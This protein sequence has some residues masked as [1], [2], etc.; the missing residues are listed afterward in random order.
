MVADEIFTNY[1]I[2]SQS[3]KN[4]IKIFNKNQIK[5]QK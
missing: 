1:L 2:Q 5:I 4:K 3:F